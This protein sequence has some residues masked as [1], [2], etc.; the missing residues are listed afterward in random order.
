MK[1][2]RYLI[3]SSAVAL[4]L[5]AASPALAHTKVAANGSVEGNSGLH[6]GS[7]LRISDNDEDKDR[8]KKHE[9][10]DDKQKNTA[11]ITIAGTVTAKS[12]ST[13]TVK[14]DNGTIYTVDAANAKISDRSDASVIGNVVV[15]DKVVVKGTLAGSVIT[16]VKIRDVSFAKRAFL[17]AIG[18][19]DAGIVTAVNG[20]LFTLKSLGTRATTTV[21]T[22]AS[23]TYKVNGATATSSALTVG[24]RAIIFGTTDANGSITA[25][26]VS[27][28]E[29]GLGFVKHFFH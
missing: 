15:G 13:L 16:A 20:S 26:L 27:I 24:S 3:A 29:I 21:T 17:S 23:T 7:L 10:R 18:A 28:L 9:D 25:S 4:S 12:G 11:D 14:A 1:I 5:L 19:A 6:L 2:T 22:N 8:S